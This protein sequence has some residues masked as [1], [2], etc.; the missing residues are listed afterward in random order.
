MPRR[1]RGRDLAVALLLG[2]VA[3]VVYNANM[4]AIPA[5]DT[6]GARYLP[7]SILRDGSLLLD[8]ILA[9]AAQGRR[10][11]AVQGTSDTAFWILKGNE[12]HFVSLYPVVVPLL[13]APLYLPA[14]AYL[15]DRGWDP[16]LFDRVAKVMEK[17]SASLIAALSVALLYLLLRRRSAP[18]LAALLSLVYAFGTT[19]WV[20]SSQALW[21]HGLAQLLI[22]AT[23]L[24][25]TGRPAA[26][27]VLAVGFLCGLIAANRQPDAILAAGL[28]LY[29]L[30]WAG[31]RFPL[32]AAGAALPV[33]LVVAYNLVYVGHIAGGYGLMA[34][35]AHYGGALLEG[36]AGLLFSP[37]RGL[38]VFSPFLLFVPCC[39]AL[40][41]R[42]RASRGL[43]VALGLAMVVQVIGYGLV[44]WRQ[45]Q[46]WGPRW[47]TDLLPLLLWML[48]PVVAG[49]R[50]P[51]RVLFAL[52]CGAAIV[53]QGIGA[54]WYT[55]RVD[56]ALF[57]NGGQE[58]TAPFWKMGN[59]PFI[60]ALRYPPAQRDL[61]LELRGSLDEIKIVEELLP[62]D[63]SGDRLERRVVIAGW[64][65]ADG[66]TPSG[67]TARV[68]GR[69]VAATNH[70]F[71]RPDVVR[72]LGNDS[73]AG[74]KIEFP[75]EQ[76]EGGDHLVSILVHSDAGAQP[77]LLRERAFTLPLDGEAERLHRLLEL[78]AARAVAVLAQRQQPAGY[79][80]TAH[81]TGL[82]FEQPRPE[83]N[84]YLNAILLDVAGPV[85][86]SIG[87]EDRLARAR[88]YLSRQI[89][90]GG[91]VRYHG[92]PDALPG[93]GLGC[94]IT[95][96]TD[97]T[98]LAWRLAPIED[99]ALLRQALATIAQ[100]RRPDGLYRTWLA[101]QERY[102]CI[103]PGADP[104][105]ADIGIQLNLLM[106]LA[107]VD[108]P[109]ARALCE[110]VARKLD[111]DAVWVYY[112]AA[113]LMV[114][115][116][117]ADLEA[118]GCPLALP[119]ARLRSDVTG[120]A[121][122]IELAEVLY[123]ARTGPPTPELQAQAVGLLRLLA[124]GDFALLAT[125]PPLFYHNDLTASVS[126]YYWSQDLGYALWLRLQVE[127]ERM[128]AALACVDGTTDRECAAR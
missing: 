120:Q 61:L 56:T 117:L 35:P 115:L 121:V 36:L 46:S 113:P 57:A 106:L 74:W 85:A 32:L 93:G 38:F 122:W 107:Q 100:F 77:R 126:R 73:P 109:A 20:I 83:L 8:P 116:R 28:G 64:A 50:R 108:P 128:R 1:A 127:S 92:R 87:L 44:D 26:T 33:G 12:G 10:P 81:T 25:L 119:A 18:P 70:F 84:T 97:D 102:Q 104:N 37:A 40:V 124:A 68:D 31:R 65:L 72:A 78:S 79:W 23:L 14:V 69:I 80:L 30:W 67:V 58:G 76:L 60:A 89:E 66:R 16:L 34:K 111:D 55:N 114:L 54:F 88:A 105:P 9:T 63:P 42:D 43:T 27:R 123:R 45:G 62:A 29:A 47:L 82:A 41:L 39:L 90:E 6:Y 99:R 110:A 94:A 4:R 17:L 22:V 98:A 15:E 19:T 59:A 5:A 11:P 48:P 51:G 75:A 86:A 95:P 7:F 21:Q 53:I 49:L 71:T 101:P 2:L 52:A 112:A 24:L 125:A 118:V 96:D 3:L 91:L 103:D 13:I